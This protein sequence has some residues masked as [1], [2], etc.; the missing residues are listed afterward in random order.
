MSSDL[1]IL[2]AGPDPAVASRLAAAISALGHKFTHR[3]LASE[4][5]ELLGNAHFDMML[6]DWE[7]G[8]DCSRLLDAL[9]GSCPGLHI[10]ALVPESD[11]ITVLSAM[12]GGA[13]DCL[14]MDERFETELAMCI[15]RLPVGFAAPAAPRDNAPAVS[16]EAARMFWDNSA[17]AA[18]L[19][20][21]GSFIAVSP[22]LEELLQAGPGRLQGRQL[23]DFVNIFQVEARPVS[24]IGSADT[25]FMAEVQGPN[26]PRGR[27]LIG[28]T[29]LTHGEHSLRLLQARDVTEEH[30]SSVLAGSQTRL[31][32]MLMAGI[33]LEHILESLAHSVSAIHHGCVCS[34]MIADNERRVLRNAFRPQMDGLAL[35]LLDNLLIGP[36]SSCCG[37]AAHLGERVISSQLTT[38]SQSMEQ[39]LEEGAGLAHC[40]A[41]PVISASGTVLGVI[42]IYMPAEMQPSQDEFRTLEIAANLAGVAMDRLHAEKLQAEVEARYRNLFEQSPLAMQVYST[43][44]RALRGNSVWKKMFAD[45]IDSFADYNILEDPQMAAQGLLSYLRRGFSGGATELPLLRTDSEGRSQTPLP[46]LPWTRCFIYSI[47]NSEG[48]PGEVLLVHEDL[49]DRRIAEESLRHSEERLR[50][51]VEG[52]DDLIFTVSRQGTLTAVNAAFEQQ[53]SHRIA[54]WIGRSALELLH[55][56]DQPRV[57]AMFRRLMRGQGQAAC[58]VRFRGEP[59]RYTLATL[60]AIPIEEAGRVSG[61]FFTLRDDSERRLVEEERKRLLTAIERIDEMILITDRDGRIEYANPAF[62]RIS[63]HQLH[64][65]RQYTPRILRSEEHDD[66][67]YAD[68]WQRLQAGE[69]WRGE[70]VNRSANGGLF[71]V[72]AAITPIKDGN[73]EIANYVGVLRDITAKA[74]LEMR[75][76]HT[77]KME[78]IGSLAGGIAHDFNN[79]LSAIIGYTQIVRR[80]V[81]GNERMQSNLDSVLTA[82]RRATELVRQIL[83]FSQ[84]REARSEAVCTQRIVREVLKLIRASLPSTIEIRQSLLDLEGTVYADATQLHQVVMNL[85]T[86]AGQAMEEEGGMLEVGLSRY[87]L[88]DE[89]EARELGLACGT[90]QMLSVRDTGEG[91]DEQVQKR[92]FEPFFTTKETGRGT[93][94]G[95]S[96][97]HGI[98]SRLGGAVRVDSTRGLGSEFILLLPRS[99]QVE[100]PL[101]EPD[102]S[103]TN[104]CE[105]VLLVDDEEMVAAMS[106]QALSSMGYHVTR[107][108]SPE[109]AL[110]LFELDPQA[111]DILVT[112]QTMPGL[113]GVQLTEEIHRIRRDMPVILCTGFSRTVNSQMLERYGLDAFL[114]KP[115]SP[116]KLA[117]TIRWV[118]ERRGNAIPVG[119]L[120]VRGE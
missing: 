69:V 23:H 92:I 77:Q 82:S 84:S 45:R 60:S 35:E 79:I 110:R 62:E 43:D 31:V 63:G 10:V 48:R 21:Q 52:A 61:A 80:E 33:E 15:G 112:D 11:A 83:T 9:H 22:A 29:T 100:Q 78:A 91:M 68:M 53:T 57:Q 70:I 66:A 73:G 96:V 36:D 24:E 7:A 16:P 34:V 85:C 120:P 6:L 107:T 41:Q 115:V 109:D 47:D 25:C 49:S 1:Q 76:Q 58:E 102:Y 88:E 99:E 27:L 97:V 18:L 5:V 117:A 3:E 86:N 87:E 56:D 2:H 30:R 106:D 111:F 118:I 28:L 46:L 44:G 113:T 55:P 17:C 14:L 50:S 38:D 12:R 40:V 51:L 105:R 108:I 4:A 65:I 119:A 104:G 37:S 101:S 74:Q 71:R 72:D 75:L 19:D 90:Y 42:A 26:G 103:N 32:E 59:D 13:N 54:E 95:L 98:I 93:G 116:D 39:L 89:N 8:V 67:F 114:D 64:E 20:E 94:L 81:N